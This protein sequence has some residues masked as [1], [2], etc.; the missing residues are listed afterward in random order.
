MFAQITNKHE[1][2]GEELSVDNSIQTV[3]YS[4]SLQ[5]VNRVCVVGAFEIRIG[6]C[7]GTENRYTINF[8]LVMRTRDRTQEE[9]EQKF[10]ILLAMKDGS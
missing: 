2:A 8:S 6:W 3:A 10:A 7:G 9:P 5:D 1:F 4:V